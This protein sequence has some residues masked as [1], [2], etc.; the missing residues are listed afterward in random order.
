[1]STLAG[2]T[3]A[4]PPQ[5]V[6]ASNFTLLPFKTLAIPMKELCPEKRRNVPG[7]PFARMHITATQVIGRYSTPPVS[8]G[9]GSPASNS[10]K[11]KLLFSS[12]WIGAG[13]A[14]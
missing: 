6:T 4:Y 9:S 3:N 10:F 5:Q 8:I 13:S 1:V 11:T 2:M 12:F 14:A 7:Y